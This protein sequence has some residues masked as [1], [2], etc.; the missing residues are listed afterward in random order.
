MCIID[1]AAAPAAAQ[2]QQQPG[3]CDWEG[4][5]EE[6]STSRLRQQL[7]ATIAACRMDSLW[8][9]SSDRCSA[10]LRRRSSAASSTGAR[11]ACRVRRRASTRGAAVAS[12]SVWTVSGTFVCAA[13][14]RSARH[15]V[16]RPTTVAAA[17][18]RPQPSDGRGTQDHRVGA[19]EAARRGRERAGDTEVLWRTPCRPSLSLARPARRPAIHWVSA[20]SLRSASCFEW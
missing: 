1:N 2:Q 5:A 17:D 6:S 19:S 11:C 14:L 9:P 15:G 7:N 3:D 4:S 18:A 20:A 12:R 8:P 13:L 10:T 16:D